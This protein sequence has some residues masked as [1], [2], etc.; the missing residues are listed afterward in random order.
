MA[1][2]PRVRGILLALAICAAWMI[3]PGSATAAR[4]RQPQWLRALEIRSDAL[5]RR[6][7]LGRYADGIAPR[8]RGNGFDWGAATVGAGAATATIAALGALVLT[9][10]SPRVRNRHARPAG[11]TTG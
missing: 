8:V 2:A 4:H 10:R 6:Y 7:R 5:N 9:A 3:A 11:R 1:T